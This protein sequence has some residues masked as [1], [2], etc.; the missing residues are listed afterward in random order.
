MAFV[1][2]ESYV[3]TQYG[4]DAFEAL[5]DA[6]SHRLSTTDPYVGPGC[7]PDPDL[8]ILVD[9]LSRC[10]DR[11]PGLVGRELGWDAFGK[12]ARRHHALLAGHLDLRDFVGVLERTRSTMPELAIARAGSGFRIESQM[13]AD[14]CDAA[15]GLFAA[16]AAHFAGSFAI[17]KLTCRGAGDATCVWEVAIG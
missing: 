14:L 7:Y 1:A 6:T 11:A 2:L 12:L 16:V 4:F 8:R 9:E 15:E 10:H 3:V 5:L 13:T 17:A